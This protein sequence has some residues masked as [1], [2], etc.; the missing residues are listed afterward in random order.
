M[1]DPALAPKQ[2]QQNQTGKPVV[3]AVLH[4]AQLLESGCLLKHCPNFCV[5]WKTALGTSGL[6]VLWPCSSHEDIRASPSSSICQRHHLMWEVGQGG[7][8]SAVRVWTRSTPSF[9]K[10]VTWGGFRSL[11]LL[12]PSLPFKL[13]CTKPAAIVTE[14]CFISV[15]VSNFRLIV[16]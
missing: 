11:R 12:V 10:T 13:V 8:P 15:A 16:C 1:N 3:A 5:N 4:A 7:S 2:K 9:C 14:F 6:S